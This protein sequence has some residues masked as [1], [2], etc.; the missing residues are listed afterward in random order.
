MMLLK[1]DSVGADIPHPDA[2][3]FIKNPIPMQVQN[4]EFASRNEIAS[5]TV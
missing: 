1:N 2:F 3:R 5:P 4:Y